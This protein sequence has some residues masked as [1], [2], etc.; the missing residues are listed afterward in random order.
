MLIIN[1]KKR[2]ISNIE[3]IN[4]SQKDGNEQNKPVK[5]RAQCTCCMISFKLNV[6]NN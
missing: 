1:S 4:E 6:Q 3:C 2:W 5:E